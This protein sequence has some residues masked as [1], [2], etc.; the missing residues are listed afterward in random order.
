MTNKFLSDYIFSTASKSREK[1]Q[2]ILSAAQ[3]SKENLDTIAARVNNIQTRS[4]IIVKPESYGGVINNVGFDSLQRDLNIRLKELYDDSNLV[5]LLL[6]THTETLSSDI[7]KQSDQIDA[8]EKY[9]D[10]YHFLLADDNFYDYSYT[11]SFNDEIQKETSNLL[12]TMLSDRSGVHFDKYTELLE[13]DQGTGSLVLGAGFQVTYP[14]VPSVTLSNCSSYITSDT[15]IDKLISNNEGDGWRVAISSPRPITSAIRDGLETGAQFQIDFFLDQPSIS[16]SFS[17]FP[18]SDL[19]VELTSVRIY[20]SDNNTFTELLAS[21]K[22]LTSGHIF[23]FPQQPVIRVSIIVNQPVY[24]RG[25]LS[26]SESEV[27]YKET[28]QP[29]SR[30][31][32]GI[33]SDRKDIGLEKAKK[34]IFFKWSPVRDASK[35]AMVR[36]IDQIDKYEFDNFDRKKSLSYEK[37]QYNLYSRFNFNNKR[38]SIFVEWL[39][40]KLFKNQTELLS[41]YSI[42]GFNYTAKRDGIVQSVPDTETFDSVDPLNYEYSLGIRSVRLG[43]TDRPD[44]GVFVSKHVNAPVQP[45]VVRIKVDDL[46]YFLANTYLDNKYVT[47]IE[48]S[49]TSKSSISSESDWIPILPANYG[50]EI[51]N[52]RLFPQSSGYAS[53]RFPANSSESFSIYKNGKRIE[54]DFLTFVRSDDNSLINGV[55]IP[56]SEFSLNIDDIYTATYLPAGDQTTV[57]FADHG[58]SERSLASAYDD[59]GVGELFSN[60]GQSNQVTL[61]NYPYVN[62]QEIETNGNYNTSFGLTG[63]YQPISITLSDGTIA[64]N[65]TNYTGLIQ[66]K[67]TP[68]DSKLAFVHSGKSI[69]F[70]KNINQSFRIYYQ[71][72]PSYLRYR[73]I[74]RV[75]TSDRTS[76]VVNSLTTKVKMGSSV[77]GLNN[78]KV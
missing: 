31:R 45:G 5:S 30:K 51:I 55:R 7:K 27:K 68:D 26:P 35:T 14:I 70:N 36:P 25:K 10:N 63:T 78:K 61:G 18:M 67:L 17:V 15:G 49:V 77:L 74:F 57:V 38:R 1:I 3:T 46:N 75:N 50:G 12:D 34:R 19:P 28:A 66:N 42:D 65:Y 2:S 6:D 73:I 21:A 22:K 37:D 40:E 39:I 4:P 60:T 69:V 64:Y 33:D 8:F 58:F 16:D 59:N 23:Y 71:Y 41:E 9:I 11:E 53:I 44:R 24:T 32:I 72:E 62:Y 76:P 29:I 56:S 52:E 47:S 54:N 13:V 48:Y 43:I 20:Q